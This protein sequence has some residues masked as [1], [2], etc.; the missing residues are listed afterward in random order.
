MRIVAGVIFRY[1]IAQ[2]DAR[3]R[4]RSARRVD[5]PKEKHR[6]AITDPK[7]LGALLRAI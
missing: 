2:P 1:A 7:E 6:A 3:R 4:A 5:T